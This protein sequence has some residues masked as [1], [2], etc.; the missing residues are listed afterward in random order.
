[1]IALL[2]CAV[3][4]TGIIV[5]YLVLGALLLVTKAAEAI[6]RIFSKPH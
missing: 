4:A 5:L 2:F 3:V 1:M 6:I